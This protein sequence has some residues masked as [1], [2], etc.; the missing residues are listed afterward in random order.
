MQNDD[1]NLKRTE[2]SY[3]VPDGRYRAKLVSVKPVERKNGEDLCPMVRFFFRLE[4]PEAKSVTFMAAR[5]FHPNLEAG[6]NLFHFLQDWLG[7]RIRLLEQAEGDLSV[8]V[9]EE[10]EVLIRQIYTGMDKP[11]SNLQSIRPLG[12]GNYPPGTPLPVTSL[13]M[14]KINL[15]T[16]SPQTVSTNTSSG[17]TVNSSTPASG[18]L[19]TTCHHCGSIIGKVEAS[20]SDRAERKS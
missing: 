20:T 19:T 18:T 13:R 6:S 12:T 1:L 2:Q 16:Q 3:L 10:G 4:V 8:F 7:D 17:V 11:F 14:P 9:G 5:N 15:T